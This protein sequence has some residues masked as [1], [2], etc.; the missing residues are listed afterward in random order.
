MASIPANRQ[1]ISRPRRLLV[2]P[3]ILPLL[4]LFYSLLLPTEMRIDI[5]GQTLFA[6]RIVALLI[7]PWVIFRTIRKG[8]PFRFF[9]F[10]VFAGSI[11]MVLSFII[12]YDVSTGLVRGGALALDILAPYVI[13]RIC[14]TNKTDLRRLL[15]WMLPG[16]VAAGLVMMVESVS[17]RLFLRPAMAEIF[18]ALPL[19]RDGAVIGTYQSASEIRIGLQRSPGPFSHPILAGLFMASMLPLFATSGLRGWPLWIGIAAGFFAIFSVSSAAFLALM[20][21]LGLLAYDWLQRRV[22]VLNWRY[23][24]IGG[25]SLIAAIQIFANSGLFGIIGRFTLNPQTAGYRQLIW[26]YGWRSVAN[27]PVIGIGYTDYERSAWML[28]T[29]DNHWLLLAIRHGILTPLCFGI[30]CVWCI[31][32][33][34]QLSLRLSETD[35]RLYVGMAIALFVLA[36]MAFTVDM[37][38]SMRFWFYGLLGI[39]ASLVAITPGGAA[40]FQMRTHPLAIPAASSRQAG[41]PNPRP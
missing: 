3:G 18:G 40:N 36:S 37:F 41:L 1:T 34:A 12:Y 30:F 35:R 26:E 5:A 28:P 19:Y 33:L 25:L 32:R 11:W 4:L 14:I 38:G 13:A 27:H 24:T 2:E 8:A 9:D 20:L 39:A 31:W 17:H 6:P 16:I 22:E 23:F 29:V 7:M 10:W 21:T 15:I